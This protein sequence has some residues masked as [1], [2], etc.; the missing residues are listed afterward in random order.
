M[1]ANQPSHDVDCLLLV[2]LLM[3]QESVC[4]RRKIGLVPRLHPVS[5][6]CHHGLWRRNAG[7][8]NIMQLT[9]VRQFLRC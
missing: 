1:A 2:C 5:L 6:S 3:N 9:F 8:I 7:N 4:R